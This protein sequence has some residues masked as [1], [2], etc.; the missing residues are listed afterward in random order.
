MLSSQGMPIGISETM[1]DISARKRAEQHTELLTRELSHRCKNLFSLVLSTM[2]QTAQHSTSKEDF[3]KRLNDRVLAMS[4]AND[5]LVKGDWKGAAVKDLVG[6]SLA[7]FV[8]KTSLEIDGPNI[9]LTADAVQCMSM[10]LHELATNA[11]KFGALASPNGK[12]AVSWD[13]D[14][15]LVEPRFRISWRERDG[16]SAVAPQQTGF[17]TEVITELLKFELDA[18]VT[19][20]Y[21]P[22]GLFWSA[23]MPAKL[24]LNP[25]W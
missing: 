1:R 10:V 14:S 2:S 12:I 16:P 5:L 6:A 13:L 25:C 4:Q 9:I 22:A 7:P 24:A 18:E 23:E 19:V 20:D 3:I 17:G 15:T 8:S 21:A 11:A